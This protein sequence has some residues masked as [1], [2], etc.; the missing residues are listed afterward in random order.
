MGRQKC[1]TGSQVVPVGQGAL[2]G[3]LDVVV[4]VVLED[5]CGGC[6]GDVDCMCGR[7]GDGGVRWVVGCGE[8]YW[9]KD[10]EEKG[11]GRSL[12]ECISFFFVSV[13]FFFS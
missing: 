6:G 10:A 4:V 1:C 7:C 3:V 5:L 9:K 2:H 13:V 11:G 12:R 8:G